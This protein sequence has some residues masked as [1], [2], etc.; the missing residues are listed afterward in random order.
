MAEGTYWAFYEDAAKVEAAAKARGFT[1]Q[2][3]ESWHDFV[4]A[5]HNKFRV[6]KEFLT[7]DGAERW[8][9]KAI[10]DRLTVYGCATIRLQ[11]PVSKRC[12]ACVCGGIEEVREYDVD[13]TG[14]VDERRIDS[15]CLDD[16]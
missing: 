8:L 11:R 5:E 3:G 6:A 15:P 4:E 2:D 7:R 16:E 14:I 10:N 1:G 13:D 9:K 12:S